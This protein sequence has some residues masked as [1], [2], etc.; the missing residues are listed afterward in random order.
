MSDGSTIPE[1]P[2]RLLVITFSYLNF[3]NFGDYV[4]VGPLIFLRIVLIKTDL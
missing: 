3:F 1:S 4:M 2:S